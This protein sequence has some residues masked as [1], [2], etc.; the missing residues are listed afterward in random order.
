M[1]KLHG[2]LGQDFELP[3]DRLYDAARHYWLRLEPGDGGESVVAVGY[4][5]P[6]AALTGGLVQLEV[7]PEPGDVLV[8]DQEIAFATT[9][10]NMK[11]FLSPLAALV[12]AAN[13]QATAVA[14]NETPYD[15]WLVRISPAP[16]W[17]AQL[18][19]AARYVA[20]LAKSEHATPAAAEAGRLGKGSPT[21]K[22]LYSGIKET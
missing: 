10:K 1:V 19:D 18:L 21:C 15:A 4:S 3:E 17:E 20:K 11:Y 14:V 12:V 6:G 16:G 2:F 7:F 8:V 22:S 5:G 13:G 9:K